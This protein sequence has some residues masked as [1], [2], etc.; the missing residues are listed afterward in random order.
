MWTRWRSMPSGE[1]GNAVA[2]V[3]ASA[4][5]ADERLG[6]SRV[7]DRL[8]V[9]PEIS[10]LLGAVLVFLFFSLVTKSFLTMGG[11]ANW[12][13]DAST[14]GLMAVPVAL[15]MIGGEFDLSAG[16]M[17]ASTGLV[18]ALLAVKAGWN[19]WLALLVSLVFALAVGAFNGWMVMRTGLPSFIV[20][21]GTFLALQG[22]NLGVTK[23][24]T[25]TVLVNGMR[26]TDGYEAAGGVVA[27]TTEI[28]GTRARRAD[29]GGGGESPAARPG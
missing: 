22:I 1:P 10:A 6:R 12:L 8:V 2:T 9:R 16:V 3:E 7:L 27:A 13:D 5:A 14:L 23:A 11:V 4:P 28:G 15:L 21:L 25:G 29:G 26:S 19:V 18:T 20:T 24:V 17:T